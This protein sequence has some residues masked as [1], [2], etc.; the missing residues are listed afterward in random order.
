M[1]RRDFD[2]LVEAVGRSDQLERVRPR[3]LVLAPFNDTQR[4]DPDLLA[5]SEDD[6]EWEAE[7]SD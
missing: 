3:P 7:N 5:E 1:P 2:A 6:A 4:V